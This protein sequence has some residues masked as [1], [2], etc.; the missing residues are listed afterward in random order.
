MAE[1]TTDLRVEYLPLSALL[2]Y[3]RNSRTHDEAQVAQIAGS[4]REF[5]FTNPI[6]ISPENDIIAG[7]GRALAVGRLTMK[8]VLSGFKDENGERCLPIPGLPVTGGQ[9]FVP[10]I[11]LGHLTE[12]QRRAYV[13]A[14]NRLALN[15]GWDANMLSL[16]LQELSI[17]GFDLTLL[18]M[19]DGELAGLLG[20]QP[21]EES[22]S[23]GVTPPT[24][25]LLVLQCADED[26]QRE[27]FE[28]M[29]SR[30]IE[31]KIM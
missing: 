27:L 5:G 15:A 18:G 26:Q 11:R 19:N 22:P 8:Q 23:P 4:I 30:G 29:Q 25:F 6:L 2:P 31:C 13:I 3:A 20:L 7:H 24:E 1:T 17:E 16:E 28:E 10:C 12:T 9:V 14:D 21:V